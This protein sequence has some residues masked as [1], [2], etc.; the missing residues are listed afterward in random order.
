MFIVS[1]L[2][3]DIPKLMEPDI[4]ISDLYASN[5]TL[6]FIVSPLCRCLI[7]YNKDKRMKTAFDSVTVCVT[8]S[9]LCE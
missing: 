4:S 5:I 1:S 2:E 8:A 3:P 9:H 6:L 7:C